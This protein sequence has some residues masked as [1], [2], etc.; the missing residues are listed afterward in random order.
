VTT[1]LDAKPTPQAATK[2]EKS[3][4]KDAESPKAAQASSSGKHP[5]KH[6]SDTH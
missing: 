5:D 1:N 6:P 3:S 2:E 4:S